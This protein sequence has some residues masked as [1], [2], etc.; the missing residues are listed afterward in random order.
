MV[1]QGEGGAV[2]GGELEVVIL[3]VESDGEMGADAEARV[4]DIEER[5][6]TKNDG[7]FRHDARREGLERLAVTGD[8]SGT[9]GSI[10]VIAAAGTGRRRRWAFLAI[11]QVEAR[12]VE[13][14]G[15]VGGQWLGGRRLR[16]LEREFEVT[17]GILRTLF[18][19]G[20]TEEGS[21][22]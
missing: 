1:A 22:P 15:E 7:A 8:G 14:L 3:A 10:G 19:Q 6:A 16:E 11:R 5:L 12:R 20:R 9:R 4:A 18:D 2:D 17:S 21:L 13:R